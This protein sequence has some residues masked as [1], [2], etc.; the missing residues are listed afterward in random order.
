MTTKVSIWLLPCVFIVT[1]YLPIWH[2]DNQGSHAFY[3]LFE[4]KHGRALV[5]VYS[6]VI[7][8][9]SKQE[10]GLEKSGLTL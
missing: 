8:L 6:L 10:G 5:E 1:N 4:G 9:D 3:C 7:I 2:N